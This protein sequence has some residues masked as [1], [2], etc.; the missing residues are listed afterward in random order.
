MRI[1][2]DHK[3]ILPL[4]SYVHIDHKMPAACAEPTKQQPI[5]QGHTLIAPAY[6]NKA[7]GVDGYHFLLKVHSRALKT[8]IGN[9][10][11]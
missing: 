3:C 11:Q 8:R 9:N 2:V 7:M 10:F 4:L 5:T 1:M 6:Y